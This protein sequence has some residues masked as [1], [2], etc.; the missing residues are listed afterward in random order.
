MHEFLRRKK[1]HAL[2]GHHNRESV[3]YK[4]DDDLVHR[5]SYFVFTFPWNMIHDR[6]IDIYAVRD[7][8]N[9]EIFTKARVVCKRP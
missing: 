5:L 7:T 8:L 2:F 4:V 9:I 1:T 6:L 3:P